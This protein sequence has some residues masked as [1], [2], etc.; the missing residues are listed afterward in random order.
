MVAS[1]TP[2]LK[3][4]HVRKKFGKLQAVRD[5]S[6][7][8]L[9]KEI[10][11]FLGPNGAGKTTTI[12]MILQ[13]THPNGGE[14]SWFGKAD[15]PSQIIHRDIGYLGSDMVYE[16][17][18]SVK[19]YL[20]FVDHIRGGGSIS[21]IT[22]LAH[23]LDIHL[24]RKIHTLSRGNK[25]KVGLIAAVMHQP[26]LLIMDE[27]TSGFDPLMQQVF[28]DIMRE[29]VA[30]GGGAL[31]SSHILSEI[32]HMAHRVV[33]IA[34]GTVLGEQSVHDLLR[35][36]PQNI[37]LHF[38][39]QTSAE[40]ARQSLRKLSGIQ[41]NKGKSEAVTAT[42]RGS[43]PTLLTKLSSLKPDQCIIREAELEEIFMQYYHK[44]TEAVQ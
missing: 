41:V 25:Q 3:L 19:Q 43:V 13:N 27:P 28:A 26:K 11:A 18:L 36:S 23:R 7:Q 12:R 9:P 16:D 30:A 4:K 24:D 40:K 2:L 10:V 33:F 20:Y 21:R 44:P 35:D 17:G 32:Q 37:E 1:S 31:I 22:D 8:V 15:L 38:S 6:F 29:H 42:Y 5:A 14:I 39:T 34:E